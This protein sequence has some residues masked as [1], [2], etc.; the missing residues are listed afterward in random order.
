MN[1]T[2]TELRSVINKID[3]CGYKESLML[4]TENSINYDPWSNFK[5]IRNKTLLCDFENKILIL[6]FYLGIEI[7]MDEL[8]VFLTKEDIDILYSYD[9]LNIDKNQVKSTLCLIPYQQYYV[10]VDFPSFFPTCINKDTPIY[11]GVDSFFFE[12]I[13][14]RITNSRVLDI[15]SGSGLHSIILEKMENNVTAIDISSKAIRAAALNCKINGVENIKFIKNNLLDNI[16]ERFDFIISNPPTQ[17][18]PENIEYP[19]IGNAG[20]DGLDI[21]SKII[22]QIDDRLEENGCF[23][24]IVQLMGDEIG[25]QYT[26]ILDELS[27]MNK[28]T[29]KLTIHNRMTIDNQ[30]ESMSLVIKTIYNKNIDKQKWIDFYEKNNFKYLYNCIINIQKK[31]HYNFTLD[32][33]RKY[34]EKVRIKILHSEEY[35]NNLYRFKLEK[36]YSFDFYQLAKTMDSKE[37]VYESLKIEHNNLEYIEFENW[38]FHQ[39]EI[40][41]IQ[42]Y[43]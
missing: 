10:F 43:F 18:V 1:E 32:Y 39:E 8:L 11:L 36:S 13:M 9:I 22:L 5:L 7:S 16:Q 41:I 42:L 27:K 24:S 37:K 4:L 34:D 28:W 3:N 25:P 20:K 23:F 33:L 30:I 31:K 40:G 17:I 38:I 6:L 21:I 15:C 29:T 35:M 19:L 2:K 14:P 26:Q 12:N